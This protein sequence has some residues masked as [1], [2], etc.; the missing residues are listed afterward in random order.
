MSR[1]T[2]WLD[3][4]NPPP[5]NPC[6]TRQAI[7]ED[8]WLYTGDI[9]AIDADGFIAIRDR[10]K[11]IIVLSGGKNVSPAALEAKLTRDP[12]IAQ[13]CVVGDRRKHVSAL[14]VP[15]FEKLTETVR[16]EGV[17]PTSPDAMVEEAKVKA[18]IAKLPTKADRDAAE[19]QAYCPINDDTRLGSMGP[20]VKVMIKGKPV[21]LC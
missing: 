8:G 16:P 17:A 4:C 14:I 21:F 7:S 1:R 9:A 10:K 2:P 3:G 5:A 11:E 20:P 13:A 12:L 19:A 6:S 15:D 18:N